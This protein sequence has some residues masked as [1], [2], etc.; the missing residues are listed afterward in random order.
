MQVISL[1]IVEKLD[2]PAGVLMVRV[3]TLG[4]SQ[5]SSVQVGSVRLEPGTEFSRYD[6][7]D[8]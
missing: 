6:E 4:L 8:P 7:A 1:A 2:I 5:V 3:P